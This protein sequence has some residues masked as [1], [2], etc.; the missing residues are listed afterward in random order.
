MLYRG[1]LQGRRHGYQ[2]SLV[3]LLRLL[4]RVDAPLLVFVLV[5]NG[6]SKIGSGELQLA[7]RSV[8]V[9][10]FLRSLLRGLSLAPFV[11]GIY[12]LAS[13]PASL[14]GR[15][16]GLVFLSVDLLLAAVGRAVDNVGAQL[17]DHVT[18]GLGGTSVAELSD[19]AIIFDLDVGLR[20][21]TALVQQ[22]RLDKFLQRVCQRGVAEEPD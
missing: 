5:I 9:R 7:R 21:G 16:S 14:G 17:V 13:G 11:V 20:Q 4:G 10:Y 12:K 15:A 2:L 3:R 6:S 8:S 19:E 18:I 22:E 1:S